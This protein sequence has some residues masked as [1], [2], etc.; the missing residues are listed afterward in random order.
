MQFTQ[1]DRLQ[2]AIALLSVVPVRL[3]QLR[4]ASREPQLPAQ[5]VGVPSPWVKVLSVWRQ[6][7]EWADGTVA[8]FF[9]ALARLGASRTAR[10]ITHPAGWCY[11]AVGRNCRPC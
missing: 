4:D 10:A 1:A 9:L 7:R 11:G 6:G 3:L 2:P 8:E 5:P